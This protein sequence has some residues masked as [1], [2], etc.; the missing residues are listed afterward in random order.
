[1]KSYNALLIVGFGGPEGKDEVMPF[2][3]NALAGKP[4]PRQRLRTHRREAWTCCGPLVP[5]LPE[6]QR[7]A[8]RPM[9]GA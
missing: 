5:C 2:L 3:E 4:V 8:V 1:M 7:Q 9:A 6:P